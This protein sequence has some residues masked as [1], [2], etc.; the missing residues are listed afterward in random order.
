MKLP[1]LEKPKGG[2]RAI[3]LCAGPVR[4]WQ[5]LRRPMLTAFDQSSKRDYWAFGA[6]QNA[7]DAV[8]QQAIRAEAGRA[9]GLHAAG[10]LWDGKK[11]YESFVLEDLRVRALAA[12]IHP[13]VV[14]VQYNFWRGPRILR[15]GRHHSPRIFY[16]RNGLPAGDIFNDVFVKAYAMAAF[17]RFVHRNPSVRL[18][19]YV[20]D[21]TINA[22]GT[23]DEVRRAIKAAASD[24]KQ[25]F[26]DDL[27]VQLALPKLCSVASS[28]ALAEKVQKDLKELAGT[29]GRSAVN[30]GVDYA[31]AVARCTPFAGRKRRERYS[32]MQRRHC[33][34]MRLRK[35]M[36][37]GKSR[38]GR[39]YMVGIRPAV[40]FGA[41]V[42]GLSD[43]ELLKLR[44]TLVSP[45]TPCH[46]G[47][48]LSAKLA[49]MGD[50]AWKQAVAP[51]VAW[52]SAVWIAITQPQW[53]RISIVELRSIW[54]QAEPEDVQTW[55]KSRGSSSMSTLRP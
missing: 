37:A 21:D 45:I 26:A 32:L 42:N 1:L 46:G 4:I 43:S 13:V 24:L 6:G 35:A 29:V 25:V 17:D 40:S 47:V 41:P 50:P 28:Q 20:D 22:V 31:P 52:V 30:L 15:I 19:S 39:L 23:F 49:L 38:L 10:V 5:R 51:V 9:Q 18:A 12:R 55:A 48:S 33:R 2:Y 34:I 14:K 36:T 3:L 54:L 8:W 7:E 27:K 44:R 11:Y 53:A 16:A